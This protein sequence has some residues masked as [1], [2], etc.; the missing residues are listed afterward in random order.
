MLRKTTKVATFGQSLGKIGLLYLPKSGRTVAVNVDI[1]AILAILFVFLFD[2]LR[3]VVLVTVSTGVALFIAN[4]VHGIFIS[5]DNQ[6][7]VADVA[8]ICIKFLVAI[9][10][11]RPALSDAFIWNIL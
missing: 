2:S 8:S 3:M 5:T 1:I 9:D 11:R 7:A 10:V 4:A 6:L